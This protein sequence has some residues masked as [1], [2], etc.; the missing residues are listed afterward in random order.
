MEWPHIM[1]AE[2][3][4]HKTGTPVEPTW[5][6]RPWRQA[7]VM[8]LIFL[9]SRL[10]RSTCIFLRYFFLKNN[11]KNLIY[12]FINALTKI[13]CQISNFSEKKTKLQHTKL[14]NKNNNFQTFES[15]R[16][17]SSLQKTVTA[18]KKNPR[19]GLQLCLWK[20]WTTILTNTFLNKKKI[21]KYTIIKYRGQES[22]K[23]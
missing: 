8:T 19:R 3:F 17:H 23:M 20:S 22:H 4:H 15:T 14:K 12:I 21:M 5:K 11:S 7:K 10:S 9:C 2:Y 13:N 16:S 6:K 1:E 18:L